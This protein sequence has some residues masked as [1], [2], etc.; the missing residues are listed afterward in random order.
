M[1]AR[2]THHLDNLKAERAKPKYRG[3][4][5][6]ETYELDEQTAMLMN[7]NVDIDTT[8]MKGMSEVEMIDDACKR[9][10]EMSLQKIMELPLEELFP[11]YDGDQKNKTN[12]LCTK[13]MQE[14]I[15]NNDI[16]PKKRIAN[17]CPERISFKNS[18]PPINDP[19]HNIFDSI[20]TL[21]IYHQTKQ[22]KLCEYEISSYN[23]LSQIRELI[24]CDNDLMKTSSYYF[25]IENKFYLSNQ[26]QIDDF[27]RISEW[28]KNKQFLQSYVEGPFEIFV[29]DVQIGSIDICMNRPYVFGHLNGCEHIIIFENI[30]CLTDADCRSYF[31]LLTF[32]SK[33]MKKPCQICKEK[34]A[35]K[36]VT[37]DYKS[38]VDPAFYCNEC[39]KLLHEDDA[40]TDKT[41]KVIEYTQD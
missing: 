38:P 31:P 21:C 2:R 15:L 20:I 27:E 36:C 8:S 37:D 24:N 18:N 16:M 7:Q 32:Q 11:T 40:P 3:K 17:Y 1:K 23:T 26:R 25:F 29:N 28:S 35:E 12:T 22:R 33:I 9:C 6:L 34:R 4:D 10:S 39:F 5:K 19:Q 30:R 13:R 14:R 41:Y